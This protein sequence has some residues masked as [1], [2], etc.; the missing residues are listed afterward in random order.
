MKKNQISTIL[1]LFFIA[2]LISGC[3]DSTSSEYVNS[4]IKGFAVDSASRTALDSVTVSITELSQ[5]YK[6]STT[7]YFQFLNIHMP[8]PT[9]TV[10]LVADRNGYNTRTLSLNLIQEDTVNVNVGMLHY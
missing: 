4:H 8:R 1:F 10:T 9:W 7:G 5:S 3:Q 2:I 6:T